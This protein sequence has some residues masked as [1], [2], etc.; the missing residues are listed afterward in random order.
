MQR[1]RGALSIIV[2]RPNA[3]SRAIVRGWRGKTRSSWLDTSTKRST[4]GPQTSTASPR[5]RADA[6][7]GLRLQG[8]ALED[9]S[10]L[11]PLYLAEA[12]VDHD[13]AHEEDVLVGVSLALE[14]LHPRGLGDQQHV[15]DGVGQDAVDLLRHGAVEASQARFN[16]GDRDV[17]L[18]G[19]DRGGHRGVDVAAAVLGGF[20]KHPFH[21]DH[22]FHGLVGMG[23]GADAE[24]DVRATDAEVGEED[25]G[26]V[27]VVVLAGVD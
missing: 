16:V 8:Q 6:G 17:E 7:S 27:L 1:S 20:H 10:R 15:A 24:C 21:A 3:P 5:W 9:G 13:V 22:D 26:E 19:G 14:V 23:A 18:G 11:R 4:A 25:V 12:G 2:R